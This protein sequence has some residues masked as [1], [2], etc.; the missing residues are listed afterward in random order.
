[1]DCTHLIERLEVFEER[2]GVRVEALF[3]DWDNEHYKPP[4]S[5]LSIKGE[6]HPREGSKIQQNTRLV[7]DIYDA[8][9]RLVARDER[10]FYAEEFFGF[11]TFQLK[12]LINVPNLAI[13]KIR[14]YPKPT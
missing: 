12:I 10:S 14:L 4:S 8:L 9:T 7:A 11:E 5:V 13:T 3:A 6:L 2:M 1:M